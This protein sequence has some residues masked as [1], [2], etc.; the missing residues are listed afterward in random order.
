M[1]RRR[2]SHAY[3]RRRYP[4]TPL[5][6]SLPVFLSARSEAPASAPVAR[7]PRSHPR[8]TRTGHAR[9]IRPGRARTRPGE[10]AQGCGLRA[11]ATFFASD[12]ERAPSGAGGGARAAGAERRNSKAV[13]CTL[14]LHWRTV[15]RTRVTVQRTHGR[16]YDGSRSAALCVRCVRGRLSL[17]CGGRH[18][19]LPRLRPAV[20]LSPHS[21]APQTRALPAGASALR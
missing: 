2:Y 21:A 7:R 5:W 18:R 6:L 8:V 9:A 4:H 20:R 1:Q 3:Q 19:S 17:P 10:R 11:H 13:V 16:G 12:R 14:A 15:R